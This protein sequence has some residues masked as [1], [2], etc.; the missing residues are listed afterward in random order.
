MENHK[1]FILDVFNVP[2]IHLRSFSF[3]SPMLAA[4][5]MSTVTAESKTIYVLMFI[6]RY[7]IK[8]GERLWFWLSIENVKSDL[9]HETRY[10]YI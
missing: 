1:I 6:F 7:S 5:A 3:V 4:L 8:V 2:H 10:V 9:K